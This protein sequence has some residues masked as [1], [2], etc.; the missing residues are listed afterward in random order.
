MWSGLH[1]DRHIIFIAWEDMISSDLMHIL[2]VDA[3]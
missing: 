3:F 1:L 2:H